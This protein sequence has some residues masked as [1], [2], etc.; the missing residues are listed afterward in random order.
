MKKNSKIV[1][2]LTM[3][4][5]MLS[6]A[7][8][9]GVNQNEGYETLKEIMRNKKSH[10][11]GDKTMSASVKIVDNGV[12]M[13][14]MTGEFAKVNESK[15]VSGTVNVITETV[16]KDLSF[17]GKDDTVYL[18]DLST[19]DVYRGTKAESH[20]G[21][22]ESHSRKDDGEK[23]KEMTKESEAIMDYFVGD[24]AQE[25]VLVA[26]DDGT[27]DLSIELNESNMPTIVNLMFSAKSAEREENHSFDKDEMMLQMA[28]FPLFNEL[29]ESKTNFDKLV[30]DQQVNKV[31]ITLDLDANREVVGMSGS[32]EVFGKDIDGKD[33]I[34]NVEFGMTHLSD[35]AAQIE[36]ID[37][38]GKIIYELP[39]HPE[40]VQ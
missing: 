2:A 12:T 23:F 32:V 26:D 29:H 30:S 16:N 35:G 22:K 34:I 13:V 14:Q 17:Y 38:E 37:L 39:T 7:A 36:E 27:Q 20:D 5:L 31:K 11:M 15:E 19:N 25:F 40:A 3:S 1:V 8:F 10:E 18:E 24:L 6:F 21:A 28:E 33:H 4:M 9:A